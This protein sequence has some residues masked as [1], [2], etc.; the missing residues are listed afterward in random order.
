MIM[1]EINFNRNQYSLIVMKIKE[2][3]IIDKNL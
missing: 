1:S 3:S 2:S